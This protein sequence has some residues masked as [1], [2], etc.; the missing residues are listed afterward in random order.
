MFGRFG[1][2]GRQADAAG[3]N[4]PLFGHPDVAQHGNARFHDAADN[5]GRAGRTLQVDGIRP[6]LLHNA[7]GVGDRF[8]DAVI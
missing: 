2:L 3:K 6:S 8:A 5:L 4:N 1:I 7:G